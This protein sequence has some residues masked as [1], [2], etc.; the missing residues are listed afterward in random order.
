MDMKQIETELKL[1]ERTFLDA[2]KKRISTRLRIQ[3]YVRNGMMDETT[4]K[5]LHNWVDVVLQKNEEEIAKKIE[6]TVEQHPLWHEWF[7]HVKGMGKLL[8][9]QLMGEINIDNTPHASALWRYGGY[10]TMRRCTLCGF[11]TYED[12]GKKCPYCGG[13]IIGTAVEARHGQKL[14]VNRSLKAITHKIAM[15]FLRYKGCFY[16]RLYRQARRREEE[17]NLPFRMNIDFALGYLLAEDVGKFKKGTLIKKKGSNKNFD[18]IKKELKKEG[19][20]WVMVIRTDGHLHMRALR[21]VKKMFL[22]HTWE[23][24]RKVRGLPIVEPYPIKFIDH[25]MYIPPEKVI[26]HDTGVKFKKGERIEK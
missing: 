25:D 2:Q 24:W 10:H 14:G 9:G 21:I 7:V 23:M 6:E 26:E 16:E 15:Q 18:K 1:L 12:V 3:S 22:S 17:K 11:E 4:A 19:R 5:K 20:N 13:L 8:A